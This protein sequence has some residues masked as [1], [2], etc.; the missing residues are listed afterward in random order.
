MCGIVGIF[1]PDLTQLPETVETGL[2]AR[3]PSGTRSVEL[4]LVRLFHSRLAII[5][6]TSPASVQP[7]NENG[8]F[9]LCNGFIANYVEICNRFGH[10]ANLVSDCRAI[11]DLYQY[12]G[13]EGFEKLRGQFAFILIDSLRDM[14]LLGRDPTGICPLYYGQISNSLIVASQGRW[15]ASMLQQSRVQLASN[16]NAIEDILSVGYVVSPDTL[17][18]QIRSVGPGTALCF[19]LSELSSPVVK[20]YNCWCHKEE[21]SVLQ[22]PYL[23]R[24]AVSRN[25]R[26]DHDPWLLLSGGLDSLILLHILVE[27]GLRPQV[28]TLAYPDGSNR[29]EV[30]ISSIFCCYYG[31]K[32]T[33][34]IS[35]SID[36]MLANPW[37][38]WQKIDWPIDGGSLLPKA[39]MAKCLREREARVV[40]GGT[41]A[42]ELFGG[43]SRHQKLLNWNGDIEGYYREVIASGGSSRSV[44][45]CY[46]KTRKEKTFAEAE[47]IYDLL[48]LANQHNPRID[49]C[50]ANQGIEYRPP[51]QDIDLIRMASSLPLCVKSSLGKPKSLLREAYRFD[52]QEKFLNVPKSP[53][54]FGFMGPTRDWRKFL[55]R[56]W[57]TSLPFKLKSDELYY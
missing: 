24:Q 33:I 8:Y 38:F 41:G 12:E 45:E 23:L 7:L 25:V 9:L 49:S 37:R 21:I 44:F 54:R 1:G 15:I 3:G 29:E 47:F 35:P 46:L 57:Y 48:E 5:N 53:L 55:L 4:P 22:I 13:V 39:W 19:K 18:A 32:Q 31:C 56:S 27:L 42:D 14:L 43:Y 28:F 40:L 16:Q 26:G 30:D 51:F 34:E 20:Q 52:I 2:V 17:I 6:T 50:F 11:L 36:S 10:D